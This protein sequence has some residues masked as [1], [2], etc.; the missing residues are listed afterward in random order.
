ML[1]PPVAGIHL[2]VVTELDTARHAILARNP[3]PQSGADGVAF[4]SM[5]EDLAVQTACT[6]VDRVG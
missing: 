5:S 3:Y 2:H 1:G 6:S 4:A